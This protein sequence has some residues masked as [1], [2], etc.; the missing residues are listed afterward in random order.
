MPQDVNPALPPLFVTSAVLPFRAGGQYV[1]AYRE[2]K[3]PEDVEYIARSTVDTLI[4]EARAK[5]FEEAAEIV[6]ITRSQHEVMAGFGSLQMKTILGS[7]KAARTVAE[8]GGG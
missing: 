3:F 2:R 4:R 8:N 5:A 6:D 1:F 7:A